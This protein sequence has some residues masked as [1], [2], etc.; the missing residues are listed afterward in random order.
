MGAVDR[1]NF[2]GKIGGRVGGLT[3]A[4]REPFAGIKA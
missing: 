2:G 4:D 1:S 3:A